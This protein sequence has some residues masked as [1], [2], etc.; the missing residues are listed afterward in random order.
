MD[1]SGIAAAVLGVWGA[2]S[3]WRTRRAKKQAK[4]ERENAKI[5]A[6]ELARISEEANR[7]RD[8]QDRAEK[9]AGVQD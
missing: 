2:I 7:L 9:A 8:A 6:G 4:Q 3:E 5:L 1:A